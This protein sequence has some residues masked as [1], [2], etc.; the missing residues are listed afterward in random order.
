MLFIYS[1]SKARR[2][3]GS[4]SMMFTGRDGC[5]PNAEHQ[6]QQRRHIHVAY[7]PPRDRYARFAMPAMLGASAADRRWLLIS[8]CDSGG[9]GDGMFASLTLP[10]LL[11]PRFLH[12]TWAGIG[13]GQLF[14]A[15][16]IR[17]KCPE[18]A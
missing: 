16:S 2:D 11:I 3:D 18:H 7:G 8:S 4:S 15:Y 9:P 14:F 12:L 5:T 6:R 10:H 13:L 17:R 1:N